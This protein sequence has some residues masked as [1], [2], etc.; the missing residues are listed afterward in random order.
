MEATLYG[1]PLKMTEPRSDDSG[2]SVPPS[3][4]RVSRL[5]L[6]TFLGGVAAI[7]CAVFVMA[8]VDRDEMIELT[9]ADF[10]AAEQRWNTS[11]PASYDIEI[12]V[13]GRQAA[14]YRVEVRGGV[15]RLATR[16][17]DPLKQPRTMGTWSV[18]G[19]F[20]TIERDLIAVE[21][22]A[23]GTGNLSSSRL[24]LRATFDSELGIPRSYLRLELASQ[25]QVTWKVSELTLIP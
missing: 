21:Q 5:V 14:T 8:L 7:V 24:H 15:V 18:P 4:R 12:E 23:A 16:N 13:T 11:R 9:R 20:G 6:S 19:M 3:R 17:G 22:R 10:A 25:M 1:Q 2:T